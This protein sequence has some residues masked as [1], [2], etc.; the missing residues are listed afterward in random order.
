MTV[1][2][3]LS[4]KGRE[5]VTIQPHRTLSEAARVLGERKI[6]AVVVTGADGQVLGIL[7][8]RD[9]VRALVRGADALQDAV[10]AHMTAEV[11]TCAPDM[12]IV[13]VMEEMTTGRFR[14]MPVVERGRLSGI[15]SIGDV[16]K[17]RL[18]EMQHETE[19]L[20]DYITAG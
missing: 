20:R 9:I 4:T 15:I 1:S 19:A 10:S 14:H 3:I 17:H 6:G 11:I 13:D 8:E 16:V 12:L 2:R 18:N 5:V 7:S